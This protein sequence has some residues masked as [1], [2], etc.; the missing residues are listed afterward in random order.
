MTAFVEL[1]LCEILPGAVCQ[2]AAVIQRHPTL[3]NPLCCVTLCH[4]GAIQ[5]AVPRHPTLANSLYRVT[6]RWQTRYAVLP[7]AV[8]FA[9]PCH[10]SLVNLLYCVTLCHGGAIQFAVPRHPAPEN[11]AKVTGPY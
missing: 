7:D 8:N 6:R 9:I 3:A 5:F 11:E 2:D 1:F 4:G 10:L